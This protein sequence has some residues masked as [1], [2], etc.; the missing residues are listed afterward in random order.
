MK[1]IL[2]ITL[3]CALGALAAY[4]NVLL[5]PLIVLAAVML[6]DYLTGMAAACVSGTLNS[7]TGA[8][9][10]LKK[11]G[12]LAIVAVGIAVDYLFSSALVQVGFDAHAGF[13]FGMMITVWLIINEL[14]SILENLGRLGIPLPGFLTKAVRSLRDKVEEKTEP[15]HY[16]EDD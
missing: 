10:I 2:H 3:A 5:V 6:T 7:R 11:A 14:I 1:N 12:C 9:G 8:K 13:C 15:K 16:G 4:L